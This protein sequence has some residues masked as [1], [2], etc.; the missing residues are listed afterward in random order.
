MLPPS[1]AYSS[2]VQANLSQFREQVRRLGLKETKDFQRLLRTAAHGMSLGQV[3]KALSLEDSTDLSHRSAGGRGT[4]AT[5]H[6]FSEASAHG[7]NLPRSS[8]KTALEQIGHSRQDVVTWD[9]AGAPDYER[10]KS[11]RS[12]GRYS[13]NSAANSAGFAAANSIPTPGD[14]QS[15]LPGEV[16]LQRQ[17]VF[18][19]IRKLD[20]G[21]I[22]G[23]DFV[24]RLHEM[25]VEVPLEAERLLAKHRAHGTANFNDFTKAF[26]PHFARLLEAAQQD[27]R[28]QVRQI[29]GGGGGGVLGA[30]AVHRE[31][32]QRG[33]G[34]TFVGDS[35]YGAGDTGGAGINTGAESGVRF[36][37]HQTHGDILSWSHDRSDIERYTEDKYA[38][39][40]KADYQYHGAHM[41]AGN[42]NLIAHEGGG[43]PAPDAIKGKQLRNAPATG[44]I[45][46][47]HGNIASDASKEF[48]S[49][50]CAN[51]LR[52]GL[53][54]KNQYVG[55]CMGEGGCDSFN[56]SYGRRRVCFV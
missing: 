3:L 31:P 4:I 9:D 20:N 28:Y 54:L 1:L 47:W 8:K 15:T 38:A 12:T 14:K 35:Q 39:Q 43:G 19:L 29:D 26:R 30:A 33:G 46:S 34:G 23:D 24:L 41:H 51:G 36:T 5:G 52:S 13:N 45:I 2:R 50:V 27:A 49:E 40:H 44:D 11:S 16:E 21:T 7:D 6:I 25:G 53:A 17:Q 37:A 48:E 22:I 10:G 18:G 55:R 56:L 32:V 42:G